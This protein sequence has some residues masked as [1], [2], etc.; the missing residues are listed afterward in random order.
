[1]SEED[2]DV[3]TQ[4]SCARRDTLGVSHSRLQRVGCDME[5]YSEATP[6]QIISALRQWTRS[7]ARNLLYIT[8]AVAVDRLRDDQRD[9]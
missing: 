6:R 1:V 2:R 5:R 8:K 4:Q 7:S 9:R 3:A